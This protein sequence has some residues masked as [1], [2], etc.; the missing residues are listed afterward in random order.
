M[1][2][3]I[4]SGVNSN[5]AAY[6]SQQHQTASDSREAR[7]FTANGPS[8]LT[9]TSSSSSGLPVLRVQIAQ[10][11]TI[12]PPVRDNCYFLAIKGSPPK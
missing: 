3:T 11:L 8:Q 12:T 7:T 9:R 5:G 1:Y 2:P 6:H 4:H 10:Q